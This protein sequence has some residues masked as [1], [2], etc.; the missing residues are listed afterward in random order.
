MAKPERRVP[1]R[2]AVIA[3]CVCA[4]ATA[5]GAAG[6]PDRIVADEIQKTQWPWEVHPPV[7]RPSPTEPPSQVVTTDEPEAPPTDQPEEPPADDETATDAEESDEEE[8]GEATA[9]DLEA[10]VVALTQQVRADN[11]CE[12][13]LNLD[14]RL[15]AAARAHSADMAERDYF[16]HTSPDGEGPGDRATAAGY[17]AW[18]GENIAVGYPTA[19]AVIDGWMDSEGHRAN[20]LNCGFAAIGVGVAEAGDGGGYYWT[21]SFGW[22]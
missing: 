10:E 12:T 20:I 16:D 7:S 1:V 14:D 5:C 11:G 22:E 2:V 3:G 19:Q 4:L 21:Q 6:D 8:S 9:A 13:E 17:S 18:G 15:V